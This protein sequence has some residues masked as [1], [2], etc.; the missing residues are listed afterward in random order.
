[1][2]EVLVVFWRINVLREQINNIVAVAEHSPNRH[3]VDHSPFSDERARSVGKETAKLTVLCAKALAAEIADGTLVF[4]RPP[5]PSVVHIRHIQRIRLVSVR[6][7]N[8]FDVCF[9]QAE[10]YPIRNVPVDEARRSINAAHDL[11]EFLVERRLNDFDLDTTRQ[12]K[13]DLSVSKSRCRN[14]RK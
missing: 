13:R 12:N 7:R 2:P 9:R 14:D 4:K 1:V 5:T 11:E 6:Y 10:S 8:A 3:T